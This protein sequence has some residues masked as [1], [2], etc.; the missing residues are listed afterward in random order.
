MLTMGNGVTPTSLG[1]L[2]GISSLANGLQIS[3]NGTFTGSGTIS[4]NILNN[5]LIAPGSAPLTF[6]GVVTNN[7]LIITN[8][9]IHLSG[10]LVNNGT[11]EA[12][13]TLSPS[14]LPGSMINV[15]YS[16]TITASG[17]SGGGYTLSVL[18]GALPAG[19]SFNPG[20]GA[21]TGTPTTPGSATF[22]MLATDSNSYP[23]TQQYTVV[24]SG[25]FA[26]TAIAT[27]GDDIHV[28]W[29]CA[30][31]Y[32][33]ILQSTLTAAGNGYSSNLFFDVS[34]L[35]IMGG[36]GQSTTNYLDAGAATNSPARFYRVRLAQ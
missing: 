1:L 27:Q 26:I 11:L 10:G 6:N 30:G 31:G 35:I 18:S 16:Q 32:T 21:I 29:K 7:G 28:T 17:G 4:G 20:T 14:T 8:S 12:P 34:P 2:G 3:A 19:L 9:T 36:V 5:G 22:T 25:P 15:P 24:T 33:N 23:G 13:V